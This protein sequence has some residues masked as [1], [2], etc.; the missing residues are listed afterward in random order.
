MISRKLGPCRII[1]VRGGM[2]RVPILI[3]LPL[4]IAAWL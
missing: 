4:A 2:S 3:V 1:G